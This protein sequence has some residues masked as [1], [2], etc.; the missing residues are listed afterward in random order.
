MNKKIIFWLNIV[1][2]GTIVYLFPGAAAYAEVQGLEGVLNGRVALQQVNQTRKPQYADRFNAGEMVDPVSGSLTLKVTDVNLP[3]KDGLDLSIGRIYC[4][5]QAESGTKEVTIDC[6]TQLVASMLFVD[7]YIQS[8]TDGSLYIRRYYFDS[9][10]LAYEFYDLFKNGYEDEYEIF[11]AVC[12]PDYSTVPVTICNYKSIKDIPNYYLSRYDLGVGWSFAFPSVQIYTYDDG[13]KY[14]YFHEGTGSVYRVAFTPDTSD[15]NLV[16]YQG[17]EVQFLED[18][19]SY[20]NG[21]VSSKYKFVGADQR[22]SFFAEDGRLLG[23]K[24]RFGNEIR[25]THI[26]RNASPCISQITDSIGRTVSFNYEGSL[27]D[28]GGG[29]ITLSVYDPGNVENLQFQY[30]K[31][32]AR[33]AL[34]WPSYYEY[35]VPTL[36][37]VKGPT[38][39]E[40]YYEYSQS[41]LKFDFMNKNTDESSADSDIAFLLTRVKYG[42]SASCYEYEKVMRNLGSMGV[43]ETYRVKERYDQ[44]RKSGGYE[45]RL[46]DTLYSYTGDYTGYP[47]EDSEETTERSGT[48]GFSSQYNITGGL[49]CKTSFQ[50]SKQQIEVETTASNG[51]KEKVQN[52]RFDANFKYLPTLVKVIKPGRDD[53]AVDN[54]YIEKSYY[55]WGGLKTVTQL[56][57]YAQKE[58]AG[59]KA[60]YT[61]TYEYD[62]T[63][64]FITRKQWYRNEQTLLSETFSYNAEGRIISETNA[65]GETANYSYSTTSEGEVTEV[66]KQLEGGKTARTV[67]VRGP[68]AAYAFPTVVK[69]FYTDDGG[70]SVETRTTNTYDLLLG[71]VKTSADN[72]G[73][74]TAYEYDL[75]GMPTSVKYPDFVNI[76]GT[77]YS[78]EQKTYID[79]SGAQTI[80]SDAGIIPENAGLSV[81]LVESETVFTN[82]GSGSS[83]TYNKVSGYYDGFGNPR[84]EKLWDDQRGEWVYKAQYNY[85]ALGRPV[86][87]VDAAGNSSS[88]AY[89]PWGALC[90]MTDPFGNLQKS[91]YDRTTDKITGYFVSSAN[92]ANHQAD[93]ANN[94]YKEDVVE[95][96][97]DQ[98][99]RTIERR[100]YPNWPDT[101]GAISETYAY[102]I[103][104]NLKSYTDPKRNLNEDGFSKEYS[105]DPLNRVVRVKDAANQLE[106]VSY[107]ALG[108][109][110]GICLKENST[111]PAAVVFNKSFDELGQMTTKTDPESQSERYAF[112]SLGLNTRRTDR[113]GNVFNYGYD[114][115]KRLI[116]DK[117]TPAGGG[118]TDEYKYLY[119]NP[120]GASDTR[121]YVADSPDGHTAFGFNPAGQVTD[122]NNEFT[123]YSSFNRNSYDPAG[124][125]TAAAIG[126]DA[127]SY[128]YTNYGYDKTRLAKV[129]TNGAQA[130]DVSGLSCANYEYYPDGK[131]KSITYPQLAGGIYLT[132][133]YEYDKLGRLE[134]VTNKKGTEVLSQ[135]TYT[136]DNNGNIESV[137]EG[138]YDPTV[139]T[140]DKLNRLVSITRPD[141][142][143]TGYSYDLRGNRKTL[144]GSQPAVDGENFGAVFDLRN[145]LTEVTKGAV[146]TSFKYRPDGLRYEKN[147][148]GTTVQYHYNLDGKVVAESDGSGNITA[149]YI[150]GPDRVLAKKDANTGQYY[151]YICNGHGDIVQLVDQSGNVVNSYEYDEWGNITSRT[152]GISNPFKYAGEIYDQETGLYYLRARYY[153]PVTGRFISE[154]SLEGQVNNPL[155]LNLYTYCENDPVDNVDPSGLTPEMLRKLFENYMDRYNVGGSIGWNGASRT[156][157]VKL[158]DI[159]RYYKV[160]DMAIRYINGRVWV[161]DSLFYSDFAGLAKTKTLQSSTSPKLNPPTGPYVP[162]GPFVEGPK[163]TVRLVPLDIYADKKAGILDIPEYRDN[164]T[165]NIRLLG[166]QG[167]AA[168]SFKKQHIG[169]GVK[170]YFVEAERTFI[171]EVFGNKLK[172]KGA[173]DF[174]AIGGVAEIRRIPPSIRLGLARIIGLEF[175]VEVE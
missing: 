50:G 26:I 29:T 18:S 142:T 88:Y 37:C 34:N 68:E 51:E 168:L 103:A 10:A 113:I 110:S 169:L 83:R 54:Y 102:D 86:Y 47:E 126:R 64:K 149:Y 150:W 6:T 71:L 133:S 104:G 140:Y 141:G 92:V 80:G 119:D 130:E 162:H 8:K 13:T 24:D 70:A 42:E 144:E 114:E 94:S 135:Y 77:Q 137:K 25:F 67:S 14:M 136:H 89:D 4:S 172:L 3:G 39:K 174:G 105:Y 16:N 85:D 52:L 132:T 111:A 59:L 107:T 19:G 153:D 171:C 129:Q 96:Y 106:E 118:T 15:S 43:T 55:D 76:D 46:N 138:V 41:G 61:T 125:M 9:E 101:S 158:G 28:S 45:G 160:D 161:P 63:Y 91:D 32:S 98:W 75:L 30:I 108:G 151:Y 33:V 121:A 166:V 148:S 163:P 82:T 72:E 84:L 159:T 143:Q 127:S 146:T 78:V 164:G 23:I 40:C 99:D 139:Y 20:S 93:P 60:K 31:G 124:R 44:E 69:T 2:F 122:K 95:A 167:N 117:G 35:L 53:S 128:F 38:G 17:K 112:N 36:A 131:L 5:S 97:L 21:Q 116:S 1:F 27:T 87:S 65:K 58:D 155:S 73:R 152:E 123:G 12:E 147:S 48:Y 154:D 173:A 7:V 134:S 49:Q 57:T 120:F 170:G 79:D 145:R 109:I 22:T 74:T 165:A 66:T 56:L 115:Q 11:L 81:T 90:E 62:P 100:A 175:S 157:T 156:A